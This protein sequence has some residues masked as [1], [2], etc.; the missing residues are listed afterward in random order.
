MSI[1]GHHVSFKLVITAVLA[2]VL[3]GFAFALTR[4][5]PREI[6]LVVRGM[7]FYLE[8]GSVPNPTIA[9]KPGERIRIVLRNEDRGIMH[10]VAVPSLRAAVDPIGWNDSADLTIDAPSTPGTYDYW[11]RPHMAMMRGTIVVRD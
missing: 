8:N 9:V 6:T 10:D 3:S 11:C 1:W 2:V 7:A 5:E 4:P